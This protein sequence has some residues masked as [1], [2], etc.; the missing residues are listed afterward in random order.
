[1]YIFIYKWNKKA[2]IMLYSAFKVYILDGSLICPYKILDI[3]AS[4]SFSKILSAL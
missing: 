1:M 2:Y 4:R 3:R